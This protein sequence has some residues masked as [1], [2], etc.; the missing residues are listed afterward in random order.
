MWSA[1]FSEVTDAPAASLWALLSDVEGWGAWNAGIE[2]IALGGPLAV[3]ATFA[4]KPPGEDVI[5]ST[6]AA[7]EP[8]RLLTDVTELGELEIR[9]IHRLDEVLGGTQV[10]YRIEVTGSAGDVVGGEVG[11][12]VSADFPAVI[13]ALIAAA[14]VTSPSV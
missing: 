4:M 5:T 14:S 6:I 7:L 3:G 12:A 13:A 8:G 11:A 2:S 10:V 1:E 9:V